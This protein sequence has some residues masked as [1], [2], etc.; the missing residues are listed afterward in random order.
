MWLADQGVTTGWKLSNGTREFRPVQPVARDAMA[1][2]LYRLAGSPAYTPPTTS[3]FTDVGTDNVYYK[4]IAWL[5]STQITTGYP[6]G[7]YR[8]LESVNR[9][10]MAAFM[11]RMVHL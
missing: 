8:P 4:E 6:D 2:F 9:D 1:A 7:T 3:P 11:Y 5:N 10:A